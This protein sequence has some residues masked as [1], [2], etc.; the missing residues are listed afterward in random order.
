VGVPVV[1]VGL[2]SAMGRSLGSVVRLSS[3]SQRDLF[4]CPKI[5]MALF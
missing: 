5:R 2:D 3:R 1:S 4:F